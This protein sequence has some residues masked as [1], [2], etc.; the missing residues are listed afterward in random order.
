MNV[1]APGSPTSEPTLRI[2]VGQH[3][4]A[5]KRLDVDREG[6]FLV[7]CS[8]DKTARVWALPEGKLLQVLRPP[9]GPG[10]EGKINAVA[11]S[12]NGDT[13]VLAGWTS[14]SGTDGSVYLFDRDSGRMIH[15]LVGLESPVFHLSFSPD[16]RHLAASL[17][18]IPASRSGP[19]VVAAS[20]P[21]RGV[22]VWES[23]GWIEVF[24]D[25]DY[26]DAS[27][28]CTFDRA[29]RLAATCFDGLVRLYEPL[30]QGR[31]FRLLYK[32][33]APGGAQ[34]YSIAF[35]PDGERLAIGYADATTVSVLSGV[36]L[37]PQFDPN[38]EGIDS[39]DLGSVAWSADGRFLYA[40]GFFAD[41]DGVRPIVRWEKAG[42]G[43]QV[44]LAAARDTILDLKPWSETKVLFAAADPRFGGFDGNGTKCL[45]HGP[46]IAD[47]RGKRQDAFTTSADGRSLRYGLGEGERRPVRF[48]LQLRLLTTEAPADLAF[49]APRIKAEGLVVEG[50]QNTAAPRLNGAP[51][52]IA[53]YETARSLAIAPDDQHF[54]LGT[55]WSLR[56][57]GPDGIPLWRRDVPEVVWGVN[58]PSDGQLVIA[59]YGDGTVRWHRLDDGEELLALFV[60]LDGQRWI[61][62]TPQGYFDASAGADGLIG[63]QVNRGRD[64]AADFLPAAH[65]RQRF[66][67][68]DVIGHVLDTL[69]VHDALRKADAAARRE[70]QVADVSVLLRDNSAPSIDIF[71]PTNGANFD[72]NEVTIRYLLRYQGDAAQ[73]ELWSVV[74]GRPERIS[75]LSVA[76]TQGVAECEVT[77]WVPPQDVKL[78]LEFRFGEISVRSRGIQLR[79]TGLAPESRP[80]LYLLAVGVSAYQY[81]KPPLL[82]AANDAVEFA[83]AMR[84]QEGLMY[85]KVESRM[86]P[87][88]EATSTEVLG[89]LQWLT[90]RAQSAD[91]AMVF[92]SGH[93]LTDRQGSYFF[94]PHNFELSNTWGT[95]VP[96]EI[97]AKF[98][99]Q[100]KATKRI[101][102]ID[103]CHAGAAAAAGTI[104]VAETQFEAHVDVDRL[105]NELF[106]ATGIVVLTSSTGNQDS[107]EHE[108]WQHGAFT[109]ALLDG[110]AG[111]AD[112]AKDNVITIDELNFYLSTRV[113]QLTGN[114]QTPMR[115]IWGTDFPIT[116]VRS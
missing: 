87:D 29:G 75:P 69:D 79:W 81:Y 40:G 5:I 51:L 98:L 84:K 13:V 52:P 17:Y 65:F 67:R 77:V 56:L 16:G 72:K 45:D 96:Q 63:W 102:L 62:W 78:E 55:D 10:D 9:I 64:E 83:K 38:T 25:R 4:A 90:E 42:R 70:T 20:L 104:G 113:K 36:D 8:E 111:E 74:E 24:A 109:K 44:R 28:G 73:G 48:D 47:L 71:T 93:G 34:P 35:S 15:R 85:E 7:T 114:R 31:G 53:P 50:W 6:Q 86:L 1:T 100:I 27:Y 41:T 11:I 115:L 80:T 103:T 66:N 37:S 23:S 101:L 49:T 68:A 105:A 110:L 92:L 88:T 46:A 43:T 59:A 60:H 12:P 32:V 95:S 82:Y 61:A 57:F 116:R 26:G 3:T 94:L 33:R 76:R 112:F 91:V 22:R 19:S 2:E 99:R 106:H 30:D 97:L 54:V 107:I 89:G 18:G 39:G 21:A 14:T 58:V 108:D